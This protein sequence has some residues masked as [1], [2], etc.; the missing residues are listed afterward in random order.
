MLWIIHAI[1]TNGTLKSMKDGGIITA[2]EVRSFKK[3]YD[4]LLTVRCH[5]HDIAGRAEERLHF[6]IQPELAKR[7]GYAERDHAKA[8][9]RF[10]KHYFLV[11]RDIG[12]MT[13]VL[14]AT[15]HTRQRR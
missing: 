13:R 1:H 9:E 12:D 14:C 8:V 10:M 7:L 4:F 5:L 11:T 6:D 2:K 15:F 3:A